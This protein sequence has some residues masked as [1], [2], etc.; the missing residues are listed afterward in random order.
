MSTL[1]TEEKQLKDATTSD[2]KITS[3]K[4]VLADCVGNKVEAHTST[5]KVGSVCYKL[6]NENVQ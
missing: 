2:K 6:L 1:S 5:I 3:S 4:S